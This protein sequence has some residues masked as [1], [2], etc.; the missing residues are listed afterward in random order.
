MKK[1]IQPTALKLDKGLL[2][3]TLIGKQD[4]AMTSKCHNHI[5]PKNG[6]MGK[7]HI[8][9]TVTRHNEHNIVIDLENYTTKQ[10]STA[11]APLRGLAKWVLHVCQSETEQ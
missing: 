1:N 5:V 8:T 11:P 7:R 9:L 3:F 4:L 6:T 10:I 2:Y